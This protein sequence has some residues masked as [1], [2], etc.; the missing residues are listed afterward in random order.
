MSRKEYVK[1][2]ELIRKCRTGT[3]KN[4]ALVDNYWMVFVC[5]LADYFAAENPN[6][7]PNKWHEAC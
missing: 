1:L 5:D 4:P 7:D 6:F 3:A 2:A